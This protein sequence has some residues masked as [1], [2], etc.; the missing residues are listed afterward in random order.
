MLFPIQP[1]Y[2]A[3]N[4]L[5]CVPQPIGNHVHALHG[6]L[7]IGWAWSLGQVDVGLC[8]GGV[9]NSR[10]LLAL[11]PEAA[12]VSGEIIVVGLMGYDGHVLKAPTP[13]SWHWVP[14]RIMASVVAQ[15]CV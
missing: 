3:T 13:K 9:T 15:V 2:H 11:I 7:G 6:T 4:Q 14:R 12:W 1:V 8:R 10:D 5:A